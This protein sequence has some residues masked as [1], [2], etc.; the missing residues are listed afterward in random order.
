MAGQPETDSWD[1]LVY[2]LETVDPV[3]GGVGGLSNTP[4]L[5]LANRTVWLKKKL[6]DL[7]DGLLLPDWI[8]PKN[9][10]TFTG[11]PTCPTQP[12][13]N[14][15]LLLANTTFVRDSL[16]AWLS[17]DVA[18]AGSVTLT[19]IEAGHAIIHLTGALTASRT[20]NF[21]TMPGRWI[22]RN[23][24]TGAFPLSV[25]TSTGSAAIAV[26]QGRAL[27]V[28]GDGTD[29]VL[30]RTD[31]T[32][33]AM[34]GT[35][36]APTAPF[37][38]STL[39]LASTEFVQQALAAFQPFQTGDVKMTLAAVAPTGWVLMND[40]TI[41]SAASGAS[42]RAH[43]DTSAL[44][45]LIWNN[46]A[47][48]WAPVTGGRG[49]SAAA[50]FAANKPLKLPRALGR[51]LAGAGTGAGLTGRALGSFVGTENHQLAESEMPAHIHGA[52]TDAQGVHAH[53]GLTDV[54][55]EHIHNLNT[56][57]IGF[58]GGIY[59]ID[60]AQGGL[61][62]GQGKITVAVT[63]PAGSHQHNVNTNAAGL[64][65]HNVGIA[66]TGGSGAHNNMQP[67]LFLNVL[68]KL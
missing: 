63:T 3:Q 10:P 27:E 37:G 33:A 4:L 25:K 7:G 11:S 9:S 52:N 61:H 8:A 21:P 38:T 45:T 19:A 23:A 12:L 5:N 14:R 26:Q 66:A 67:T 28:Y 35:P 31:F 40:G 46:V 59:W 20:V 41:G 36:T 62:D 60:P 43:A 1:L 30:S 58:Q 44:Y 32:D 56:Q 51:A 34:A 54:Q 22:V 64:H 49:A 65:A 39:Q 68:V 42:T 2:Q 47:D 29:L 17:K 15:S 16:G 53:T 57:G 6:D 50:D 55:G 24:T 48:A 13:G 18:G